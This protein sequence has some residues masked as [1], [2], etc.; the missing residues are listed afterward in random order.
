MTGTLKSI[1]AAGAMA[2]MQRNMTAGSE[3]TFRRS[4]CAVGVS[5]DAEDAPFSPPVGRDCSEVDIKNL[6]VERKQERSGDPRERILLARFP[7]RES[8]EGALELFREMITL[9]PRCDGADT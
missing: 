2:A 1:D 5:A 3:S 4:P 9:L 8:Q 7:L 6:Q